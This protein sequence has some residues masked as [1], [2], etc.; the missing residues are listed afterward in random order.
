M[1]REQRRKLLKE[2]KMEIAKANKA[3]PRVL[4]VGDWVTTSPFAYGWLPDAM[5]RNDNDLEGLVLVHP[6]HKMTESELAAWCCKRKIM[7]IPDDI[8]AHE[9]EM[10]AKQA[11]REMDERG[12]PVEIAPFTLADANED[13][14]P[15]FMV[16]LSSMADSIGRKK[17][18]TNRWLD[19][20]SSLRRI[21]KPK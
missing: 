4:I 18:S 7:L 6:Y 11:S 2:S 15:M 3:G 10:K 9:M 21:M 14:P 16:R 5:R 17:T 13:E 20:K 12:I 1:N 8:A 19:Y